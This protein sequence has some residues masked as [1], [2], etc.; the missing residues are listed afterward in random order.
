MRVAAL[1]SGGKDS[2]Y[3]IYITQQFGWDVT[4]LITIIPRNLDSW[5]Y[6][7]VNIS[8]SKLVASALQIPHLTRET[9]GV[10]EEELEDLK[11]LLD[12][13]EIDGVISGAISSEYQRTR[14]EKICDELG[15]K[16]FTPLWHK[17]QT[18]LLVEQIEAGFNIIIVGVYAEG[19]SED[20]LGRRI[21]KDVIRELVALQEKY[22]INTAGEGGEYETLTVDAPIFKKKIILD[23]VSR[24]WCREKGFLEIKKAHLE[25]KVS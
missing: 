1:V 4:H 18:Q 22:H 10:K 14:I 23:E 12:G 21:D 19:F 6:H 2:I 7:S 20:W 11:K 25:D 15:L 17:D 24:N 13:L 8:L 5:M 16:S 3:S 9:E